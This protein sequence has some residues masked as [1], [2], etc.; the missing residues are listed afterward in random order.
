M[1]HLYKYTVIIGEKVTS[2]PSRHDVTNALFMTTCRKN[3]SRFV[4]IDVHTFPAINYLSLG[5]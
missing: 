4:Q 1:I 3:R 2:Q 5:I